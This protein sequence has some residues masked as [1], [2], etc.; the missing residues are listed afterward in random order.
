MDD[1]KPPPV[2]GN[3][4]V[5]IH[6]GKMRPGPANVRNLDEW[7]DFSA[8]LTMRVTIPLDRVGNQLI[9]RNLALVPQGQRQGFNAKLEQLRAF[10]HS[11]WRITVL[12]G[13]IP[14]SANDNIAAW[15]TGNVYGFCEPAR[16]QGNEVPTLV[17]AEWLGA[18][19]DSQDF[20]VKSELRFA[21]A[22][23]MQP[24]TAA[25]GVFV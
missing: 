22:R 9:A 19:P 20:A 8:T 15:A 21:N 11:N 5:A 4:F 24:Q 6:G 23:R 1:G 3:V 12:T 25:V 16:F 14:N 18:D 13:Q 7:Y 17:G 2:A 10:L